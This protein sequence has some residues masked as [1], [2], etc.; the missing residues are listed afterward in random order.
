MS[1]YFLYTAIFKTELIAEHPYKFALDHTK[2]T[3]HPQHVTFPI[4]CAKHPD[5]ITDET[6]AQVTAINHRLSPGEFSH[7]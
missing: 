5:A 3:F 7:Y 6:L 4:V 2:V 1:A